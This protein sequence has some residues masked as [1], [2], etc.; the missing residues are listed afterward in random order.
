MPPKKKFILRVKPSSCVALVVYKDGDK[1]RRKFVS[2][3]KAAVTNF[4]KNTDRLQA[5]NERDVP[6]FR[7]WFEQNFSELMMKA[8][9]TRDQISETEFLIELIDQIADERCIPTHEAYHIVMTAKEKN[10]LQELVAEIEAARQR[11]YEDIH[12]QRDPS[13]K[14][15]E[16]VFNELFDDEDDD[17]HASDRNDD[18][19]S[20]D[21]NGHQFSDQNKTGKFQSNDE[22]K[23]L[24]R[25]LSKQLHPDLCADPSPE[26]LE[27][28]HA[29]QD[30][31]E[32][33]DV[34]K[35]QRI[36]KNLDGSSNAEF[37]FKTIALGTLLDM[38]RAVQRNLNQIR[39]SLSMIK[40]S[41]EWNFTEISK[42]SK[43]LK[44]YHHSIK[45]DLTRDTEMM[46][47]HLRHMQQQL[48][49]LSKVQKGKRRHRRRSEEEEFFDLLF[50]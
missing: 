7:R 6:A 47:F 26:K 50:R 23:A 44:K 1:L 31:Y 5:H 4:R 33:Q 13:S 24:Y 8:H 34:E 49:S 16:D 38:R 17:A 39:R 21:N 25:Q 22:V 12:R 42:D 19:Y 9:A 2:L 27:L 11:E 14:E 37:D 43:K 29:V 15:F 32:W 36:L 20:G 28:W 45:S 18:K 3:Y 35:L 10:A 30:A 46:A 40:N 41:P 48:R